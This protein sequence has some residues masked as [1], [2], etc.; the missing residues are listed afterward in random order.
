MLLKIYY[1][2]Q[3][4][5]FFFLQSPGKYSDQLWQP[6]TFAQYIQ[7]WIFNIQLWYLKFN[8]H[9]SPYTFSISEKR[10]QVWKSALICTTQQPVAHHSDLRAVASSSHR[11][12]SEEP[13]TCQVLLSVKKQKEIHILIWKFISDQIHRLTDDNCLS[14]SL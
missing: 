7:T 12:T 13:E 9:F 1:Q 8:D 3:K 11:E 5:I 14:T 10:V 6:K 4:K 2:I